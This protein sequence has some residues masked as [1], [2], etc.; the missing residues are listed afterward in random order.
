VLQVYLLGLHGLAAAPRRRHADA[1]TA[2]L[3]PRTV[4]AARVPDAAVD[5]VDAPGCGRI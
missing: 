2:A 3:E 5:M 1:G 4:V